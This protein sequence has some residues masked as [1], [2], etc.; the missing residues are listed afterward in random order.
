MIVSHNVNPVI[1]NRLKACYIKTWGNAPRLRCQTIKNRLKAWD[2]SFFSKT[3]I[4]DIFKS[5][6][7]P[8]AL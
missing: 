2:T 6:F 4:G 3:Q 8:R 5:V 1:K 7:L